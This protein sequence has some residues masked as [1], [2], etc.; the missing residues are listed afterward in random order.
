MLL[1]WSRLKLLLILGVF[2]SYLF[3]LHLC[4]CL[5]IRALIK[6]DVK[7]NKVEI[8]S[9]TDIW[10]NFSTF[11]CHFSINPKAKYWTMDLEPRLQASAFVKNSQK[12]QFPFVCKRWERYFP[13]ESINFTRSCHKFLKLRNKWSKLR[14]L[15]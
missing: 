10:Q 3:F 1:Q 4:F 13:F 7:V 9:I 8:K 5:I 2:W 11:F 15:T 14:S 6:K 12:A